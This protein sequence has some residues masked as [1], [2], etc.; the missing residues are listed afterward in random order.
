MN[1]NI[2]PEGPTETITNGTVTKD[3]LLMMAETDL[4]IT[5]IQYLFPATPATPVATSVF[6]LKAGRHLFNVATINFTGTAT[7]YYKAKS[8][9]AETG[10]IV[11]ANAGN[12]GGI[13]VNGI[14]SPNG[15]VNGKLQ[16]DK[17][18]AIGPI[19]YRIFWDGATW[20][21]LDANGTGTYYGSTDNTT[22][23]WQAIWVTDTALAP[24]PT[25]TAL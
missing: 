14:Y 18:G 22:Y 16:Y 20:V 15:I 7:F 17:I 8:N 23:P 6:T 11:V 5:A 24:A 4:S 1:S 10:S 2:I 21:M 3:T 25:V 9:A 19:L 12:G 13:D